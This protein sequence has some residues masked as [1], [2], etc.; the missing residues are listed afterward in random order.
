MSKRLWNGFKANKIGI[1]VF[2]ICVCLLT[3]GNV[4][5]MSTVQ[6][7]G[8][9]A[10]NKE[11]FPDD[12]FRAYVK[13][14]IAKGSDTL[15]AEDLKVTEIDVEKKGIKDLKG[16][17]F[18]TELLSLTC[19][20]NQL[21]SLDVSK[22]TKIIR[23]SCGFNQLPSLDVSKNAKLEVLNC[24]GN[25]FKSINLSLNTALLELDLGGN[26]FTSIDVS[27]NTDLEVL[28]CETNQIIDLDVSKNPR[29]T[30][31]DCSE[32]QLT[33][34]DISQNPEL[35]YFYCHINQ[36]TSIDTSQNPKIENFYCDQNQLTSVDISQNSKIRS[37]RCFDN[38]YVMPGYSIDIAA[39]DGFAPDKVVS[40]TNAECD[41]SKITVLDPSQNI[42][43]TYQVS[44]SKTAIF[45][46]VPSH[47]I[48]IENSEGGTASA[49]MERAATG[50]EVTLSAKPDPGYKFIE[51]QVIEGSAT[52]SDGKFVM[53]A[54][55]V[56]IK[57]IY[58]EK[59]TPAY[60]IPSSSGLTAIYG[61]TLADVNLPKGFTF[62]D[63]TNTSV[64]SVGQNEFA[65]EYY[66]PETED[67]KE[68]RVEV[69]VKIN[70]KP[71]P[72]NSK[73]SKVTVKVN[74]RNYYA[75]N[76]KPWVL[77]NPVI[78]DGNKTLVQGKDYTISYKN[79]INVGTASMMVTFK[80]NYDG[81]ITKNFVIK[82]ENQKIS[83]VSSN[84]TKTYSKKT[85]TL[86]PK[87]SGT[88]TY[89]S[90][91]SKV[92]TV[93][94][95]TGKVT[96]KGYGKATITITVKSTKYN[97]VT[98]KVVLTVKPVKATLTKV[99]STKKNQ[100][101]VTWKK[102]SKAT[103]YEILLA[104][105]TKFTAGKKIVN[106]NGSKNITKTIQKLKAG[107][108]YYVKVRA[109]KTVSG[110]KIY[111]AYSNVKRITVK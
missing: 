81:V 104:T 47:E 20:T 108:K 7:A 95:T 103:G 106:V 75:Y 10:I 27:N 8:E 79:N 62:K 24:Y 9:V 2:T 23:L 57:A 86:K 84:I 89:K 1:M 14:T 36:L 78:K 50:T 58:E 34:M 76:G 6:A 52:V 35:E 28:S 11:N 91:N 13:D 94:K 61:N 16:I 60:T 54:E 41:G 38:R 105:N 97:T 102:D 21:T 12:N 99:D 110:K 32:N 72:V 49:N 45:T 96:L 29:L 3:L 30:Y 44:S 67:Y 31:L 43:Y 42:T 26:Q 53:P 74:I 80:G 68:V 22:N 33:S 93:G 73:T 37:F 63:S 69:T 55:R 46:L 64:G 65:T 100:M 107:K 92:A 87:A 66:I 4:E 109:Y 71:Q 5:P 90:S 98:K 48:A 101:K 39:L 25:Q 56:V 77:D 82:K 88:I 18:F 59:L 51:W 15:S 19:R 83:G 40:W 85:F 17:E 111:G 70:V